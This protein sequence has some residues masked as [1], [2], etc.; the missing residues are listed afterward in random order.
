MKFSLFISFTFF[1]LITQAQNFKFDVIFKN[2]FK[3]EFSTINHT[4]LFNSKDDS[5]FMYF[6]FKGDSL[7]SR[8]VDVK[9]KIYHEFD[10]NDKVEA[11]YTKRVALKIE[12]Y[13]FT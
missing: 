13:S 8:L 1:A 6:F 5:Y 2:S 7:K 9:N 4:N 11:T 3:S 10:I 12:K